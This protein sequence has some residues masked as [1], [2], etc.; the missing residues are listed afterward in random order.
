[1]TRQGTKSPPCGCDKTHRPDL[2]VWW[3]GKPTYKCLR[4]RRWFRSLAKATEHVARAHGTTEGEGRRSA[5]ARGA[6]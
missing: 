1:M 6:A 4:C 3:C 5:T 2:S